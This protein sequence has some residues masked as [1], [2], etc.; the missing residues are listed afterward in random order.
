MA[1]N[2]PTQENV[3]IANELLKALQAVS[4]EMDN[5]ANKAK[6]LGA[7][8]SEGLGAA[9]SGSNDSL[10]ENI[11]TQQRVQESMEQT[12]AGADGL[13]AAL[14]RNKAAAD[15]LSPSFEQI[16]H[17]AIDVGTQFSLLST[18]A[19][20]GYES[21]SALQ[22]VVGLFGSGLSG[23]FSLFQG[24][25]GIVTGFFNSLFGLAADYRNGAGGEM[26]QANQDIIK[27]FGGK[28]EIIT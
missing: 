3:D 27:Q 11:N 26:F 2:G 15:E 22:G 21:F 9:A 20:V 8:L 12:I 13:R 10:N 7:A 6:G 1:E 4:K 18:A 16:A 24:G 17:Q 25:L 28:Y 14:G 19:S 5:V 23:M